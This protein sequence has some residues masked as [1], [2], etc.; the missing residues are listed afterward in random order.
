M[1]TTLRSGQTEGR[2]DKPNAI[3]PS[4]TKL[5]EGII[6]TNFMIQFYKGLKLQHILALKFQMTYAGPHTSIKSRKR[7]INPWASLNVT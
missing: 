6:S 7:Q 5:G 2:T 3:S 1:H 4:P